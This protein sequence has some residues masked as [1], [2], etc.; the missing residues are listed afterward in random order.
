[1][2]GAE[3]AL[4]L[5]ERNGWSQGVGVDNDGAMCV[6]FAVSVCTVDWLGRNFDEF[7]ETWTAVL[8]T[9]A[10]RGDLRSIPAWNDDPLT[11]FEDVAEVLRH[12]A[13]RLAGAGTGRRL[14]SSPSSEGVRLDSQFVASDGSGSKRFTDYSGTWITEDGWTRRERLGKP[15]YVTCSVCEA[16]VL[17]V[18][19]P[20]GWCDE[21]EGVANAE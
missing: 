18:T 21:C 15:T 12:A 7:T 8:D 19:S 14:M 13:R 17:K 10:E 5:L 20:Y 4:A 9:L 3:E 6:G 1:M 2:N 16:P 11:T